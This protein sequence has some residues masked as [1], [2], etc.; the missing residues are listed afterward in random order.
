MVLKMAISSCDNTK[1]SELLA[2]YNS[3]SNNIN[4]LI[5]DCNN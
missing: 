2:Y 5:S 3:Y 1:I 4:V